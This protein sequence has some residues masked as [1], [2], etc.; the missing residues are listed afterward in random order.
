MGAQYTLLDIVDRVVGTPRGAT[1]TAVAFDGVERGFGE[2]RDRSV[3]VA[4]ALI[5]IGVEPGQRVAVLMGNRHEWPEVLFAI[6]TAGAVCVPVNVLLRGSEI[7]Y[8]CED[9]DVVAMIVDPL[10]E[11]AL[12][13][14]PDV[15]AQV[16]AVGNPVVPA[17]IRVHDYEALV[18]AASNR[19]P[20]RRAGRADPAMTYYTSGTTGTPKGATHGHEGLLWNT[21]HQV[22]D[23][24]LRRDD[25][26]LVVPSLSWAAGFHDVMLPL[27]YHG[28]RC[29]LMPTGATTLERIVE[30]VEE[31][32]VTRALLVP[33]LLRQLVQEPE[34]LARL[35]A[36]TLSWVMTGAEPIPAAML[37]QLGE[38]LP[39]CPIV[40]A[41]GMSE[42]PLISA[43]L[44]P[45]EAITH[46]G[47]AGR[48][49]SVASLAIETPEGE[50]VSEGEGEILVRSPALMLGYHGRPEANEQA[51]AHGWF[52]TGD[53][54]VIDDEGFL[55]ITGRKK[56]MII[57]GGMNIY[58]REI[59]DVLAGTE[60]VD[61]VAVVGVPDDRWGETPVAIVFSRDGGAD[62]AAV[63]ALCRASLSSYKCPRAV[64]V[65]REPFPRTLT[66]KLLK[67]E[68][69]PWAQGELA[70]PRPSRPAAG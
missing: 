23:L 60:G 15:P 37:G 20:V 67:R 13:E 51:F 52:H 7:G 4:N 11:K 59:E 44:R 69:R 42:F 70:R 65:R 34:L 1:R 48:A 5:G 28:G 25:V 31:H 61:D 49:T 33:T 36:S 32:G 50:I 9:S 43:I 55:A 38:E 18:A 56:D 12:A 14:L 17:G 22:F 54:G 24:G 29:V 63:L 19:P 41:Y 45:E 3:R 40:Q 21:V 53:V 35:R 16:I 39:G 66:G 62:E 30:S 58:P 26:Y 10:A 27:M 8:V 57:S 2:L 6:A 64:L 46:A 47:K 68:L